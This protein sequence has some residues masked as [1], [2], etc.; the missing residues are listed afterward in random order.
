MIK[1]LIEQ[2]D[3][4]SMESLSEKE[5]TSI[6]NSING[7][8]E[9]IS[10][11]YRVIFMRRYWFCDTYAEIASRCGISERKVKR[12]IQE[13]REHMCDYLGR[14]WGSFGINHVDVKFIIEAEASVSL[15]EDRKLYHYSSYLLKVIDDMVKIYFCLP[16]Q[17]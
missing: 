4:Y 3:T 14:A 10:L 6:A 8:L 5:T 17:V 9:S 15:K 1:L 12:Y 13:T 2:A 16:K 7:Y 11:E